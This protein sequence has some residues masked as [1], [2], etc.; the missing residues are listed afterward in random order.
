MEITGK[1][2][3]I[4][5]DRSTGGIAGITDV[6]GA[7]RFI[8]D[9]AEKPTLWR[10]VFR[11]E[12]GADHVLDNTQVA[13]PIIETGS[14]S[15]SLEWRSI[16]LPGEQGVVDVRATCDLPSAGD[17]ALLRL[18][19]R[20]RSKSF[21]LWSTVFPLISQLGEAKVTDVAISRG[22]WG[23]LY[24]NAVEPVDGEYPSYR[25]PMQF[26][27]LNE[28][29]SGLYLAAHDPG[30]MHKTFLYKP[31][32]E[33]SVDTAP[34]NMGIPGSGWESPFPFAIG[35]YRGDWMTGCKVYR[36]WALEHA[37]WTRKGPLTERTDV[38]ERMKQVSAWIIGRH[39]P[40]A[41]V[42]TGIDFGK[43][44]GAPVGVHWYEWHQITFDR[45]YPEYFP[46]K[47][48]VADGVAKME[49]EGI[50]VM[51]YI[52]CRLWD[53]QGEHYSTAIPYAAKEEDGSP[54]VEDYGSG[55]TL[56]VMCPTQEFWREKQL[57]IVRRLIEE[58]G[59][60]A[61][62]LDQI[63]SAPPRHCFDKTH[64]HPIG[65]GTWWVDGYREMLNRIRK[66]CASGGRQ[67]GL[68]SENNA[69]PYMDNVDSFLIWTPREQNEIP[70]ITAVY[71]GYALYFASNRAF[72]G[73]DESFCLL[74]ARDWVWGSQLG[75]EELDLLKP[76]HTAKLQ[77]QGR[78]ARMRSTLSDYFVYGELLETL[79]P[80]NEIPEITGT[81]NTW[82]G[83][84]PVTLPAVHAALWRGRNGSVA[85]IAANA[86]TN[87][88]PFTFTLDAGT[89]TIEVPARDAVAVVITEK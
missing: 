9:P 61:I 50:V 53:T 85:V 52:N 68:T 51:P 30:A 28:G 5:F 43:A 2:V 64:G 49:A 54:V 23:Q 60:N 24:R 13:P 17:T 1:Q 29:D 11:G 87:P 20:S 73:G 22:N 63:S 46:T 47:P 71:G 33:F 74:Q 18:Y 21:G 86:D 15:L 80:E 36:A 78:L 81:W 66:L 67:V 83:D 3:S 6:S 27:L 70:M 59:V 25:M 55:T 31:G 38:P 45:D 48:G 44:I 8:R 34:E 32:E 37:P 82:S 16:D 14:G 89:K 79:H 4:R 12:D 41:A 19:V 39:G 69:E 7:H 77:F 40:D 26:M 84:K 35:V 76:E 62:Y 75:W 58:V 65:S 56:A 42:P 10:L 57:E 88:H 72:A